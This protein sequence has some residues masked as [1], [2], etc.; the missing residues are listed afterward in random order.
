MKKLLFIICLTVSLVGHAEYYPVQDY[1]VFGSPAVFSD[2]LAID[3]L[4]EDLW[5][6]WSQHDAA[7]FANLHSKDA[8]WTNAFGRTFRGSKELEKFLGTRLFVGF[9]IEI[10]KYEAESY[11][12]ISRR[13]I[14]ES[15]VVITGRAESNR[16]SSVGTSN[17]KIG[18]TFVLGKIEGEWKVTN[19]VITDIRERRG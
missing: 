16:G 14:G 9:D 2:A 13:Y 6:A 15:S 8:E 19:Q 18:F 17:R 4:M 1:K 5:N 7:T 12:E 11:Q 10:A 3:E